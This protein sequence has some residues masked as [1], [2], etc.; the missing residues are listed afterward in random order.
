M[1][2]QHQE[3]GMGDLWNVQQPEAHRQP[4]ADGCIKAAEQD[5]KD[6]GVP[7]QIDRKQVRPS[8]AV[9]Y[10]RAASKGV[11]RSPVFKL[12]GKRMTCLPG[13]RNWSRSVPEIP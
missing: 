12:S 5:A 4:D 9:P 7:Q 11:T 6:H 3:S 10:L 2:R 13:W 1:T 8:W